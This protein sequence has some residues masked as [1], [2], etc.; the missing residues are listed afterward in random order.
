GHGQNINHKSSPPV[1]YPAGVPP[2]QRPSPIPV[3]NGG[4]KVTPMIQ[5]NYSLGSFP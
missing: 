1:L 3:S 4:A 5:Y 2:N